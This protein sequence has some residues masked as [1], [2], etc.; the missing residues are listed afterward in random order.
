M[1]SEEIYKI[2]T[3]FTCHFTIY[4]S[5][6]WSDS[7]TLRAMHAKSLQLCPMLCDPMDCSLPGSSV[8]RILQAK[9]LVWLPCPPPG[10]LPDPGIEPRSLASSCTGGQILYHW[11]RLESPLV[12]KPQADPLFSYLGTWG[13]PAESPCHM[14]NCTSLWIT[15]DAASRSLH[16]KLYPNFPTLFL[17]PQLTLPWDGVSRIQ[18]QQLF[19]TA[20]VFLGNWIET[21]NRECDGGRFS[22]SLQKK[23]SDNREEPALICLLVPLKII[24][25]YSKLEK[26][27]SCILK[28]FQFWFTFSTDNPKIIY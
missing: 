26:P 11:H 6:P 14:V 24:Y 27:F 22:E 19:P 2:S 15:T 7:F 12:K 9:I 17:F 23:T 28:I 1:L 21:S 10:D 25:V 20:L 8:H 16:L 5:L 13:A 18:S 4:K 3:A